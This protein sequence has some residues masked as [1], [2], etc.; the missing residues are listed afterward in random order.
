[1]LINMDDE[2]AIW[3]QV[4]IKLQAIKTKL[5]EKFPSIFLEKMPSSYRFK[6]GDNHYIF[7]YW[8]DSIATL[9]RSFTTVTMNEALKLIKLSVFL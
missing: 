4:E 8:D 7:F 2:E 3:K 5:E 1:M 6:L 9:N